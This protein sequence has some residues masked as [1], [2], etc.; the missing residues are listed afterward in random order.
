VYR[1]IGD[2]EQ[3]LSAFTEELQIQ[4]CREFGLDPNVGVELIRSAV[5][6]FPDDVEIRSIPHYVRH[7][8][9]FE[10]TLR[11]GDQPPNCRVAQLDG[12]QCDLLSLIDV[13]RPTVLLAAS[14]T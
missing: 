12:T 11:A 2:C 5:S 13:T 8:R 10:G 7:N 4:V 9:C 6:L 14:H 1:R 3:S